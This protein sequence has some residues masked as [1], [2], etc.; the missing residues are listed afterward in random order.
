MSLRMLASI[1]ARVCTFVVNRSKARVVMQ[2]LLQSVNS[3]AE[4]RTHTTTDLGDQELSDR[5][6]V[7]AYQ[8]RD[9][10]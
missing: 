4:T 5:V 6:A 7:K 3:E 2:I 1:C 10:R 9:L 8:D